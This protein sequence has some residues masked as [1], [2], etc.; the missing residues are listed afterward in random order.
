[1]SDYTP[2]DCHL[3]DHLEIACMRRYRLRIRA[4][5]GRIIVG[6][7]CHTV[8]TVDKAE[9]IELETISGSLRLRL[10]EIIQIEPL[11][12]DAE[13]GVIGAGDRLT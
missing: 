11:D 9:Y 10:D 1:M 6:T 8:T 3:H 5:G 13:F 12:P 7:A 4:T 2:I